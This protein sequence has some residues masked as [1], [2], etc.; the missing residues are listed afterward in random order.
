MMIKCKK[1][2]TFAQLNRP[3]WADL[4]LLNQKVKNKKKKHKDLIA[5]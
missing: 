5:L 4:P 2:Y 1:Y 3:F